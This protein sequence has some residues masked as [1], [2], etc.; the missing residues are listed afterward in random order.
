MAAV[1]TVVVTSQR[2]RDSGSAY[3]RYTAVWTSDASG[4][5][6]GNPFAVLPGRIE[7]I[8]TKPNG[9]G[10]APT[11]LYDVTLVD[12]DGVDVLAGA[13]AN[14][15]ATVTA[16]ALLSPAYWQDGSRTL[17]LTVA[18]AGNAKGGVL[19]ILVRVK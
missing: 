7:S 16:L 3:Q 13:G 8:R 17:D 10:T 15:S 1:G 5:V 18:N 11:T 2:I 6:S 4:N 9:G 14:L 19:E 12:T